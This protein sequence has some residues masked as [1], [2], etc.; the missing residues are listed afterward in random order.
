MG[1]FRPKLTVT[2]E[3]V[4][5]YIQAQYPGQLVLYAAD[6]ATIFGNTKKGL[7]GLAA[8]KT[9]PFEVKTFGGRKCVDIFQVAQWLSTDVDEFASASQQT[10]RRQKARGP[11]P[12][13]PESSKRPTKGSKSSIGARILEMRQEAARAMSRIAALCEDSEEAQFLSE[14]SEG[15]LSQPELPVATWRLLFRHGRGVDGPH[16][17]ETVEGVVEIGDALDQLIAL[18]KNEARTDVAFGDIEV[19]L[20]KRAVFVAYCS[21]GSDWVVVCDKRSAPW[22]LSEL[23]SSELP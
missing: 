20:G 14:F 5:Q 3:Q 17:E 12:Q 6:L 16:S 8:R 13:A 7:A 9:L 19:V 22:Y 21:D 11:S 1:F 4:L 23:G 18:W 2:Y 10:G 15:L